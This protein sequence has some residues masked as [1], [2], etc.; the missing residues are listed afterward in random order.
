MSEVTVC[1]TR[2]GSFRTMAVHVIVAGGYEIARVTFHPTYEQIKEHR[3][4]LYKSDQ[5]NGPYIETLPEDLFEGVGQFL[6]EL[7]VNE[8][9]LKDLAEYCKES[10]HGFYMGWL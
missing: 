10:E 7:D 4:S 6:A 8:G 5:Y 3:Q 2:L 1:V 9:V